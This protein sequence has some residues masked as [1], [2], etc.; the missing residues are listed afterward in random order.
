MK[1]YIY[2]LGTAAML[3]MTSCSDFLDKE[4]SAS[5]DAPITMASQLQAMLDHTSFLN[6]GAY[7][8]GFCNDDCGITKDMYDEDDP[9]YA[10]SDFGYGAPFFN[11][12]HEVIAADNY[13]YLVVGEY[14]KIYK[15][16]LAINTINEVEGTESEKNL[17]LANAYF[18]RAWSMFL[19]TQYYCRPYCEANKQQLG[20]P[21]RL[22]TEFTENITRATLEDTY[23]Q[24][25][26]DLANAEKY[27]KQDA[28]NPNQ[29]WRVSKSAINGFYARISLVM[30]D[31]AAAEKY[32]T[33]ALAGAS[34]FLDLNTIGTYKV[35][36]Y[37]E[38]DEPVK[39]EMSDM[40][41]WGT[42]QILKY[43]EF[44]Y[45]RCA[46][47]RG[48][49]LIPSQSLMDAFEEGDLRYKLFIEE[50]FS[51]YNWLYFSVP[52]YNQFNEGYKIISG[53]TTAE[54]TLIKAEAMVRQ[55]KWQEG[56]ALLTPLR[57]ARFE[58]G[59]APALSAS[60]QAEALKHVLAE[61][62]REMPYSS[63]LSDIKRYAVNE[64]PDDDVIISHTF[65]AATTAGTNTSATVNV[66]AGGDDPLLALPFSDYDV[67]ATQG[68]VQQNPRPDRK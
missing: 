30:G 38:N 1:N 54:L 10:E 21:I 7:F 13:D 6:E 52:R 12:D 22:D 66:S 26:S 20:L 11:F 55:G 39:I 41:K 51:Y 36:A 31:Y 68:S 23:K 53:L 48:G 17:V 40:S 33:A 34:A 4:P 57:T 28:V 19:M 47:F 25:L 9:D 27:V 18:D 67:N 45:A 8:H 5:V 15:C 43:D 44:V 63:R 62:H 58:A 29:R 42:S 60:N 50:G 14:E 65:Y 32:A 59:A 35:S 37:D 16:N 61:R 24:I 56:L 46:Y 2:A 3:A 49:W 64:T